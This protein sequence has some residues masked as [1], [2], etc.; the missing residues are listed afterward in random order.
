MRW[1]FSFRVVMQA[2]AAAAA[3]P[4]AFWGKLRYSVLGM[5]YGTVTLSRQHV[6]GISFSAWFRPQLTGDGSE[7]RFEIGKSNDGWCIFV[8]HMIVVRCDA[9]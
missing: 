1:L 9:L 7:W 2:A 8:S 3:G 4:A 5:K 6:V